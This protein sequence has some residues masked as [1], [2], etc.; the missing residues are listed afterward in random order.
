MKIGLVIGGA[1]NTW[2]ELD[3]AMKLCNEA[4][5]DF[6]L[7]IANRAGMDWPEPFSHW[8]TFH[9]E[10]ML[11]WIEQRAANG[12]PEFVGKFWTVKRDLRS[13]VNEIDWNL[14]PSLGGSSGFLGAQVAMEVFGKGILCGVPML[15][16]PH[17]HSGEIPWREA[18][19]HWH[20]WQRHEKDLQG[21]I[22]SM[23]GRTRDLLGYPDKEFLS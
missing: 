7:I 23:S 10:L 3:D 15:A 8:V 21:K 22:K 12:W 9:Q 1:E 4:G 14:V 2:S 18:D 13:K 17:Y 6:E 11:H 16:V 5:V 19:A 20:V